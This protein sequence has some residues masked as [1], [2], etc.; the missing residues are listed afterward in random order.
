M[1]TEQIKRRLHRIEKVAKQA[2]NVARITY[3]VGLPDGSEREIP[4][5]MLEAL[6]GATLKDVI[7]H[8]PDNI[9]AE[10]GREWH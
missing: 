2:L 3:L 5:E 9:G 4:L 7:I 6:E 1:K 10:R 8:A